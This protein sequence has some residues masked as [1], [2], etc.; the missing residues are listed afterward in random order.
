MKA[1]I[2]G[3]ISANSQPA[4]LFGASRRPIH[5]KLALRDGAGD[6][7]AIDGARELLGHFAVRRLALHRERDV[8]ASHAPA[9]LSGIS[10]LSPDR[11]GDGAALLLDREGLAHRG[12]L[13]LH[14]DPP[15]VR[16]VRSRP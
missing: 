13:P 5:V 8:L 3:K 4:A 15:G 7:V 16:D 2:H 14:A 12:A 9:N 1:G 6:G 11:S 10:L